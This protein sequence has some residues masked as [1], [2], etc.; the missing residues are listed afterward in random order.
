MIAPM[1]AHHEALTLIEQ[2]TITGLCIIPTATMAIK[3]SVQKRRKARAAKK[4]GA[5]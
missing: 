1:F 4:G 2:L 3:A 5:R